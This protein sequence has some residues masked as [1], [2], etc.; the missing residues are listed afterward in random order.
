[1]PF[2]SR[3]FRDQT[4]PTGYGADLSRQPLTVALRELR[5]VAATLMRVI[6]EGATARADGEAELRLRY[7]RGD[8]G[9]PTWHVV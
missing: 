1:M 3:S 5:L 6:A 4:V 8:P 2:D 9:A 7:W